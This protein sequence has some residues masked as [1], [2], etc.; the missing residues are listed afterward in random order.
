MAKSLMTNLESSGAEN[1][2][3][4]ETK[5]HPIVY[6]D[7]IINPDFTNCPGIWAL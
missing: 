2:E 5:G 3:L 1:I 6:A 4:I 7:K